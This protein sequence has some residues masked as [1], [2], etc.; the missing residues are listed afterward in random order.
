MPNSGAVAGR[1]SEIPRAPPV[2]SQLMNIVCSTTASARVAIEKN[3]PFSRSVRYPSASPS[4]PAMAA[5]ATIC[6]PRGAFTQ[7][8]STTAVYAPSAKKAGVPKFT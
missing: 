4:R 2:Y 7:R 3:T 5:P 6:S 8:I 1:T